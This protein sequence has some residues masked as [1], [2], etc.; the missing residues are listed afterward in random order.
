MADAP[1]V[2]LPTHTNP[3]YTQTLIGKKSPIS[4]DVEEF[5]GIPFGIIPG[6]WE[7]SVPRQSL[8]LDKYHAIQ[9]G[10]PFMLFP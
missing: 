9:N 2:E 1:I 5:R 10:Y 3:S 6:R 7:H 4:P 8:P